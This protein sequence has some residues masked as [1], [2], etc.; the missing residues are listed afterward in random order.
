MVTQPGQSKELTWNGCACL[1]FPRDIQPL[2]LAF[3]LTVAVLASSHN[4][5]A[6]DPIDKVTVVTLKVCYGCCQHLLN[7]IFPSQNYPNARENLKV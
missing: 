7:V 1:E 4:I 6:L 5:K 3:R 2:M